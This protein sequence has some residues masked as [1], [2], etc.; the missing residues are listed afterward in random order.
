MEVK[1]FGLSNFG[2]FEKSVLIRNE[3][4][5]KRYRNN[6]NGNANSGYVNSY[7]NNTWIPACSMNPPDKSTFD[8]DEDTWLLQ[9]V[10][11]ECA[12]WTSS[13]YQLHNFLYRNLT[14]NV[15]GFSYRLVN[16]NK[17]NNQCALICAIIS[18]DIR[19]KN[20]Y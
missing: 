4:N 16:F 9:L 13:S 10:R 8:Y 18:K 2:P 12:K 3:T 7:V 5:M 19:N 1:Q 15:N 17:I 6:L 11:T 14:F 20:S